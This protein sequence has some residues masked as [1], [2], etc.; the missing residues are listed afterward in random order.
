MRQYSLNVVQSYMYYVQQNAENAVREMLRD[1][2]KRYQLQKGDFLEACDYM[3]DGSA[4]NLKLTVDP[5][6]FYLS[7]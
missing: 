2:A 6:E 5:F 3:D 4:I 7:S 1:L